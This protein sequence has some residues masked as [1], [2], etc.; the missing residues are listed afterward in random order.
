LKIEPTVGL[1]L[2]NLA[3]SK[4]VVIVKKFQSRWVV[5]NS[6]FEAVIQN[7]LFKDKKHPSFSLNIQRGLSIKNENKNCLIDIQRWEPIA[8]WN[9]ISLEH[10]TGL[11]STLFR[12]QN[13][14]SVY[15]KPLENNLD[16][17]QEIILSCLAFYLKG[18]NKRNI[19]NIKEIIRANP[20]ITPLVNWDN[21]EEIHSF[22]NENLMYSFFKIT[23]K[24]I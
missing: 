24:N 19:K 15:W 8:E 6:L 16:N 17:N 22:G 9:G 1:K 10:Y 23:V 3:T 7:S 11:Y 18:V 14:L 20:N 21:G 5:G 13:H 4:F 12:N 2:N